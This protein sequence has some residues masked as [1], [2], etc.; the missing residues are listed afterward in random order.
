M[1]TELA[2][3]TPS[4]RAVRLIKSAQYKQSYFN[5][6]HLPLLCSLPMLFH[7]LVGADE[8]EAT[9]PS[10]FNTSEAKQVGGAEGLKASSVLHVFVDIPNTYSFAYTCFQYHAYLA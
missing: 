3:R 1:H 7:N 2:L 4:G 10:W 8:R 5:R 9:S 6:V